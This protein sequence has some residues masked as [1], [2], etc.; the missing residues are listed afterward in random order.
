M[1]LTIVNASVVL[2]G[3]NYIPTLFT[4]DSARQAKIVKRSWELVQSPVVTP[5]I[6]ILRYDNGLNLL[7]E[8]SRAQILLDKPSRDLTN[9]PL[10]DV[11]NNVLRR[12]GKV[13][14][15]A[16]GTNF[17]AIIEDEAAAEVLQATFL[18]DNVLHFG[19]VKGIGFLFTYVRPEDT[20]NLNYATGN[21]KFENDVH[22]YVGILVTA[23]YHVD[24]PADLSLESSAREAKE[25]IAHA[26]ERYT[27]FLSILPRVFELE[28]NNNDA[29]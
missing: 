3:Q 20:L 24:L 28:E 17:T 27:E 12:L 1:K 25:Q 18:K 6:S 14:H 19:E 11:T 4:Y 23:N 5:A 15:T 9:T 29:N 8:P 26:N 10:T 21:A 2:V 13:R 16:V 7:V 22:E